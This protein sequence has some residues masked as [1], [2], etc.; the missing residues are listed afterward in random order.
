MLEYKPFSEVIMLDDLSDERL[1]EIGGMMVWWNLSENILCYLIW[2]MGNIP[3]DIAPFITADLPN[4]S[5]LALARNILYRRH[6]DSPIRAE[7]ELFLESFDACRQA[8]NGIVHSTSYSSEEG[9]AYG[10][11]TTK[12]GKGE[13]TF[14]QALSSKEEVAEVRNLITMVGD[15]LAWALHHFSDG[16][17]ERTSPDIGRM[18]SALEELRSRLRSGGKQKPPPQSSP[19]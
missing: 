19:A 10:G 8:R 3:L 6:R 9:A 17:P 15:G 1:A 11:F 4:A 12:G 7:I 18:R 13:A 14:R 2:A 16:A 5:R